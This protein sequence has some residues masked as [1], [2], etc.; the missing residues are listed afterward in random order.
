MFSPEFLV[1]FLLPTQTFPGAWNKAAR[2]SVFKKENITFVSK[3]RPIA[4][5]NAFSKVF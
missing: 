3:Y 5:L 1:N 2:V 4:I